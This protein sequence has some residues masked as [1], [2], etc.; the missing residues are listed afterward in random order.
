M[1]G[2]RWECWGV[3]CFVWKWMRKLPNWIKLQWEYSIQPT[4]NPV[5]DS[6]GSLQVS[7]FVECESQ[8]YEAAQSCRENTRSSQRQTLSETTSADS[9]WLYSWNANEKFTKLHQVAE[10]TL[11]RATGKPCQRQCPA[12]ASE[13]ICG[14]LIAR[15]RSCLKLQGEYSIKATTNPFRY[16]IERWQV[17]IFVNC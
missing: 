2:M 9:R 8:V 17:S 13:Y 1:T 16:S 11:Y 14:L 10:R 5:R 12:M 3:W 6:V 4:A 15:L 7:L